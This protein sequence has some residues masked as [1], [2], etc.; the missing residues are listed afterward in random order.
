MSI[1]QVP[2]T[3]PEFCIFKL[4]LNY[5]LILKVSEWICWLDPCWTFLSVWAFWAKSTWICNKKRD[6]LA[7]D[8]SPRFFLTN[9]MIKGVQN[10][11]KIY[12]CDLELSKFIWDVFSCT[13]CYACYSGNNLQFNFKAYETVQIKMWKQNLHFYE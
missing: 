10:T 13:H 1:S 4:I 7:L 8:V 9:S 2:E 12:I 5:E 6:I 11:K 3:C